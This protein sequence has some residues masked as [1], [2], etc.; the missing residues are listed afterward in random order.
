L[1]EVRRERSLVVPRARGRLLRPEADRREHPPSAAQLKIVGGTTFVIALAACST[2]KSEPAAPDAGIE[3]GHIQGTFADW[4]C[5]GHVSLPPP[6]S[7]PIDVRLSL[8]GP[9]GPT[10]A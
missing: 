8:E 10:P 9:V 6:S 1:L 2:S 4:T 3:A 5:L 7:D